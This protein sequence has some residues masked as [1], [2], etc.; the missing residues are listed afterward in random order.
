MLKN[1]FKFDLKLQFLILI[2][3]IIT[4]LQKV[5]KIFTFIELNL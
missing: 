4:Y 2:P 1:E 5:L 3:K